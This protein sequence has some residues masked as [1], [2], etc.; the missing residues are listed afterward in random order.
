MKNLIF[1]SAILLGGITAATAQ[2][3]PTENT[4]MNSP[5]ESSVKVQAQTNLEAADEA[6]VTV[7]VQDYKEVKNSDV[8]QAVKDAVTKSYSGTTISKAYLNEKGEYKLELLNADKKTATVYAT[9]KGELINKA[10]ED[11]MKKQ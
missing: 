1:A 6:T 11:T 4:A 2:S 8:P 5:Q 9:E 3:K 10:K 7:A